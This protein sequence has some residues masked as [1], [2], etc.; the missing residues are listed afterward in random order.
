[1]SEMGNSIDR[2]RLKRARRRLR[3]YFLGSGV[4]LAFLYLLAAAFLVHIFGVEVTRYWSTVMMAAGT[5]LG[6]TYGFVVMIWLGI[7]IV[8]R[9]IQGKPIMDHNDGCTSAPP[10]TSAVVD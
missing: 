8:R 10:N 6:G 4:L 1:M 5:M 3:G 2:A 9:L 7:H